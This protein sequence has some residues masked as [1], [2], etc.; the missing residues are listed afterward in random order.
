MLPL[1]T[2]Y[3]SSACSGSPLSRSDTAHGLRF[4]NDDDSKNAKPAL[5]QT[6]TDTFDKNTPLPEQTATP[7]TPVPKGL[8][9]SQLIDAVEQK[10]SDLLDDLFRRHSKTKQK[11]LVELTDQATK[12]YQVI[13]MQGE[14]RNGEHP[15]LYWFDSPTL[16]NSH[17]KKLSEKFSFAPFKNH[18]TDENHKI[19]Y[20]VPH[21]DPDNV[22]LTIYTAHHS[23]DHQGVDIQKLRIYLGDNFFITTHEGSQTSV[24]ETRKTL[25]DAGNFQSPSELLIAVLNEAV[26]R[27]DGMMDSLGKDFEAMAEKVN[28]KR[29]DNAIF[30][31]FRTTGKKI[32]AL[33]QNTI[34]QKQ[35][36]KKLLN[37][38]RFHRS[39]LIPSEELLKVIKEL[40]HRLELLQHFH[41]KKTTLIELYRT[42]ITNEQNNRMTSAMTLA[43]PT[44][45][46]TGMYGM[47]ILLPFATN[48]YAMGIILGIDALVTGALWAR[49]K[50]RKVL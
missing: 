30:K 29:A 40:E 23:K 38:N 20:E 18:T 24:D 35:V 50:F 4:G 31:D 43:I 39:K 9:F 37:L 28:Q 8:S 25:I 26:D 10:R 44:G 17:L 6:E 2:L 13:L 16:W 41:D 5:K 33:F 15:Y 11:N 3:Q 21:I 48:P 36:L 14:D 27:Y 34:R 49:L 42:K 1:K 12:G 19:F 47:N 7:P 45:V 46:L 22:Q 32:D